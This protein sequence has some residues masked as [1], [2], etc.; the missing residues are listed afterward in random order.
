MADTSR[1]TLLT[2]LSVAPIALSS[3]PAMSA[4]GSEK[5]HTLWNE[6]RALRPISREISARIDAAEAA[7]PWWAKAGQKYL[8]R[9]GS[10]SGAELGWPAIRELQP[11]N[12][13][14]R[15]A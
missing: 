5:L 7:L 14:E 2:G 6:R 8:N 3:R 11:R 9:D 13:K 4:A 12:V 10:L 1:R 15:S